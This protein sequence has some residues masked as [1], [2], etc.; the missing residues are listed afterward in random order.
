MVSVSISRFLSL[1]EWG[2]AGP[3][4]FLR[5]KGVGVEVGSGDRTVGGAGNGDLVDTLCRL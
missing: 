3:L 4:G 5:M 2:T 1:L